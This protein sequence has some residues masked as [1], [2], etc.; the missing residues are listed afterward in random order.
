MGAATSTR[1]M[2]VDEKV[3]LRVSFDAVIASVCSGS[4]W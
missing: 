1:S 4:D 2:T 3:V